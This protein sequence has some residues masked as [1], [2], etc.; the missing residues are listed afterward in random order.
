VVREF[1]QNQLRLRRLGDQLGAIYTPV[2]MTIALLAWAASGEA[3]RFL[4]VLVVATP[5][6]LLIA[7]PVVI[8][9]SISLAAGHTIIVNGC[10]SE[11][12]KIIERPLVAKQTALVFYH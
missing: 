3:L 1:E 9:C 6:R 5:C 2:A 4:A 10:L 8:I 7:I 12:T 11:V